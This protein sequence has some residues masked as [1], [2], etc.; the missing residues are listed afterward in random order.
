MESIGISPFLSARGDIGDG[1]RHFVAFSA[2]PPKIARLIVHQTELE[3]SSAVF[4]VDH[5]Q[6]DTKPHGHAV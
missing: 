1:H 4:L 3:L 6:S 2:K 5:V